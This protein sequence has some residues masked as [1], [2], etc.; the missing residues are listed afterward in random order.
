MHATRLFSRQAL[1][2]WLGLALL[3]APVA[4]ALR[5]GESPFAA[6]QWIFIFEGNHAATWKSLIDYP[7]DKPEPAQVRPVDGKVSMPEGWPYGA[8]KWAGEFPDENYEVELQARRTGGRDLFCGL[9]FPVGK[10]YLTFVM[11]AWN[12]NVV[13]CSMVDGMTAAENGTTV[14][15]SFE[16]DKWYAVRLRVSGNLVEV[17]IDGQ[18]VLELERGEHRLSSYPGLE[19]YAPFGLFTWSAAAEWSNLRVRVLQ[20]TQR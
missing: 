3:F 16:N 11:G 2:A 18:Q 1:A 8:I 5:G 14:H 10:S 17:W 9:L 13:G 20:T 12:N 15:M 19:Q 6:G 7:R 4:P